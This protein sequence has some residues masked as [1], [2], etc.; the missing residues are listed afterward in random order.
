MK[1]FLNHAQLQLLTRQASFL[2]YWRTS[3][4]FEL[5]RLAQLA[6]VEAM[7]VSKRS[8]LERQ[9][10]FT[11]AWALLVK[12]FVL[13]RRSD[14]VRIHSGLVNIQQKS[15]ET[16]LQYVDR[17]ESLWQELEDSDL[18]VP[19]PFAIDHMRRGLSPEHSAIFAVFASTAVDS[20][21]DARDIVLRNKDARVSQGAGSSSDAALVAQVQQLSLQTEQMQKKFQKKRKI[22]FQKM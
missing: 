10:C 5:Q 21:D 4:D 8:M 7:P 1:S 13:L 20:F 22:P 15:G 9:K 11:D 18:H 14:A 12:Q 16:V 6:L 17:V 19:E 2:M 3:G